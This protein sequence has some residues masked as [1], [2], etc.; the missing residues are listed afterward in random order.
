M[1]LV[2]IAGVIAVLIALFRLIGARRKVAAT[3]TTKTYFPEVQTLLVDMQMEKGWPGHEAGQFAF[4][5]SSTRWGA[6][7]FTIGSNWKSADNKIS[8][9]VKELG[10]TTQ[11]LDKKLPIGAKLLVLRA[12]RLRCSPETQSDAQW[13]EE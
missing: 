6:H 9:I 7:P 2:L 8:F 4:V 12:Q 13:L 3:V 10:D 11:D 1:A 5:S